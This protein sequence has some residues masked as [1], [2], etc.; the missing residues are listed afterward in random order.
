MTI[1]NLKQVSDF[2][3]FKEEQ[4]WFAKLFSSEHLSISL[5]RYDPGITTLAIK[6]NPLRH[7]CLPF[8]LPHLPWRRSPSLLEYPYNTHVS[9][10]LTF[11]K[12]TK[13]FLREQ[14]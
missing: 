1:I 8:L 13:T 9:K 4:L 7:E 2:E 10:G 5:D 12:I 6:K 3:H 14:A 11:V